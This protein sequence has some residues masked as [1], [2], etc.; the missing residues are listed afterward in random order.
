MSLHSTE[1][2]LG[3]GALA[4]QMTRMREWLDSRHFEP[5]VFRYAHVDGVVIVHVDFAVEEEAA[6]FAS[7]F[8]GKIL[9]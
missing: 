7:E 5:A 3:D 2:R 4:L 9:R 6:A 8:H 1:I